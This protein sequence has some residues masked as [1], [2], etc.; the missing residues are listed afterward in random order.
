MPIDE[1]VRNPVGTM[2][3]VFSRQLML[4][5]EQKEEAIRQLRAAFAGYRATRAQSPR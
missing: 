5:P 4:T 2:R 3:A 1:F